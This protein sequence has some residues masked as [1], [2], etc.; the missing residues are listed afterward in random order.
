MGAFGRWTVGRQAIVLNKA[1]GRSAYRFHAR[2]LHLVMGPLR[3]GT[4]ALPLLIAQ[5]AGADHGID[6][7][8]QGI[9]TVTEHGYI[10]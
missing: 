9:G 3:G 1:N 8:E 7:D 4:R 2:D 10:S 6:F 5:A